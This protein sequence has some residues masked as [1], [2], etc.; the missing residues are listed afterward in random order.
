M[1]SPSKK[2]YVQFSDIRLPENFKN[3]AF[4]LLSDAKMVNKKI[5]NPY[6]LSLTMGIDYYHKKL[7]HNKLGV[8]CNTAEGIRIILSDN[9]SSLEEKF[10]LTVLLSMVILYDLSNRIYVDHEV[11]HYVNESEIKKEVIAPAEELASILLA[12]SFTKRE[13]KLLTGKNSEKYISKFAH[14]KGLPTYH[15]LKRI[16]EELPN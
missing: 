15:L 6:Q 11:T 7:A 16:G 5:L 4:L 8:I 9:L 1:S 13:L 12:F 2:K 10:E 14:K 3:T